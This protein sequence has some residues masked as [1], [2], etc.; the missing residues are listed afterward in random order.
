M[1][2]DQITKKSK[3]ILF[4]M[5]TSDYEGKLEVEFISNLSKKYLHQTTLFVSRSLSIEFT[6]IPY[7]LI[8]LNVCVKQLFQLDINIK[9]FH[10]VKYKYYKVF[11]KWY[12]NMI[13]LTKHNSIQ[14]S[15]KYNFRSYSPLN[16][17]KSNN[18]FGTGIT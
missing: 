12:A 3:L 14:N 9:I 7:C 15:N 10:I 13:A 2:T 16:H 6:I 11:F 8:P 18:S 17:I 1:C 5:V 4:F